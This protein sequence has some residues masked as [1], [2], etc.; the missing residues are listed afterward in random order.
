MSLSPEWIW[1][2]TTKKRVKKRFAPNAQNFQDPKGQ[3]MPLE[4]TMSEKM[5]QGYPQNEVFVI[6]IIEDPP[7][8]LDPKDQK[9][10]RMIVEPK[11]FLAPSIEIAFVMAGKEPSVATAD[12]Q[13]CRVRVAHG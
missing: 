4:P 6:T 2:E 5:G 12:L 3:W 8:T 11:A 9:P 10:P 7:M 13:R 1:G